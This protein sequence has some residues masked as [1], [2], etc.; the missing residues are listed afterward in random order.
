L[1]KTS[2]TSSASGLIDTN[3]ETLTNYSNSV[4]TISDSLPLFNKSVVSTSLASQSLPN[5][6]TTDL[7]PLTGSGKNMSLVGINSNDSLLN[8]SPVLEGKF[9]N[10]DNHQNFQLTLQDAK[11]NPESFSLT[12]DGEGEVFQTNLGEQIIFTGTDVTT[13]VQIS[14]S[15]NL[16]FG[17]YIGSELKVQTKGS[18]TSGNITLKNTALDN[19]PGLSLQSGLSDSQSSTDTGYSV[20]DLTTLLGGYAT[21]INNSGQIVGNFTSSGHPF[22]YSNGQMIDLGTM[23]DLSTFSQSF[24]HPTAINDSAQITGYYTNIYANNNYTF[25]AFLYSDGKTTHLGSLGGTH[26]VP[27][28]INSSG[29]V[30]GV[31]TTDINRSIYHTLDGSTYNGFLYSDGQ[32]T[33]LG[34]LPVGTHSTA[35]AVNDS[36]QIVGSAN[37]ADFIDAI[38]GMTGK[39]Y[40]SE[41]GF[42]ESDRGFNPEDHAFLYSNGQMTDLGTLPG[43][44]F[45]EATDI[46][47]SGQIVGISGQG[48]T[49]LSHAF[50]Y[51]GGQMIDLGTLPGDNYS[52]ATAINDSGTVVGYSSSS[53]Y[54]NSPFQAFLYSNGKMTDINSLIPQDSGWTLSDARAI[55]NK[56]Q[57]LGDGLIGGQYHQFLLTPI[58]T[59][60]TPKDGITVGN[61]STQG[62][63]VF[64]QGLKINLTGSKVVTKGGNITLDGPT[65]LNSSTGAYTFNSA[66]STATSKGG[67]ITFKN[68]LDSNSAG[69]LSLKL[70]AGLG[71][72]TFN[73]AV[74]GNASLKDLTVNSA[75]T[76]TAKDAIITSGNTIISATQDITTDKLISN[77][78]AVKLTSKQ[79]AVITQDITSDSDTIIAASQR[80]ATGTILTNN[81]A[82]KLTSQQSFI[83]TKNITTNGASVTVIAENDIT[84]RNILSNGGVIDLVSRNSSITTGYLRSDSSEKEGDIT[85]HSDERRIV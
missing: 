15:N 54:G 33:S 69:A 64:L 48:I 78:G 80:I 79:G 44:K 74:G 67:D 71:N 55:N 29:Q 4:S 75:K 32:M 3:Q 57:I 28:S 63:S 37:T 25:N 66:K 10:F 46:N 82:V 27:A 30:I 31:S 58:S 1:Q 52:W 16:Q 17:D 51:S 14:A 13:K 73:N 5:N 35:T 7:D 77:S 11:G 40:S 70:T 49:Y 85:V 2:T 19:S 38:D 34:T 53:I 83:N 60:A 47:N 39:A 45:S 21:A 81:G 65:I 26:T 18:I 20:T 76:F 41:P 72:I 22:L 59:T 8:P 6:L 61:I 43:G 84:T 56:G 42:V 62:G 24:Y 23:I 36:G 9:G 50:L 12:G 68:T